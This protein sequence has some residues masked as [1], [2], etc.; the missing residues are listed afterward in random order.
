MD[1]G[2]ASSSSDDA[3]ALRPVKGASMILALPPAAVLTVSVASP[4]LWTAAQDAVV[5]MSQDLPGL[6]P[7]PS[8]STITYQV[9][10]PIYQG[11]W[12]TSTG[13]S[14]SGRRRRVVDDQRRRQAVDVQAAEGREV[15]QRAGA[16]RERREVLVDRI[17]ETAARGRG[18][19][20]IIES[21]QVVD[22]Q[23]VRVH[24]A[25]PLV[26]SSR[27][28]RGTLIS[29]RG[30]AGAGVQGDRDGAVRAHRVEDQRARAS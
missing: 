8:T 15:P 23:T 27:G 6:D 16:C 22:P 25:R 24:L 13:I 5:G 20:A 21:V 29:A 12:W 18:A 11:R 10:S 2:S 19:L 1:L 4:V 7:H 9:L 28:W 30:G 3:R 14:S 17:L 26:R